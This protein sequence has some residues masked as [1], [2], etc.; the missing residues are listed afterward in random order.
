[1]G[2]VYRA[3]DTR[4]GRTVALKILPAHMTDSPE[5]MQRFER[6]ARAISRCSHPHVCA[7]YDVGH[8]D[9]VSFLVLEYLEGETLATRLERGPLPVDELLRIG[10]EVAGALHA[11]HRLGIVHRDLKP[12]NIMLTKSGAKLLD[13]G[14]AK[15]AGPKP[16]VP[17]ATASPTVSRPLTSE[18][19]I[20]GTVQYMAPEQLEGLDSGAR[21]DV[22]AL[23]LVLYEMATGQHPFKGRT[24]ASLIA[25]ILKEEPPPLTETVPLFPRALD[26]I[27]RTCLAKDPDERWQSAHDVQL[28]L[29]RLE[30]HPEPSRPMPSGVRRLR[31]RERLAWGAVLFLSTAVAFLGVRSLRDVPEAPQSVRASLLPPP[32]FSFQQ[33]QFAISPDGT[34][35]AFVGEDDAARRTLWVRSLSGSG[36]QQVDGAEDAAL[37]FWAPDGRRIG[38]FTRS[39]KLKTVDLTTGAVRELG[40]A[41]AGRGGTWNGE[42]VIVFSPAVDGPL[43]RVSA[44]G[45]APAPATRVPKQDGGQAHR[46]PFF[47]PDGKRFFFFVDWS[48]PE[49]TLANGIYVGSLEGGDAK[50][51]SSQIT[52]NVAYASGYLLFVQQARLVAQRFDL[53]RLTVEGPPI[54]LPEMELEKELAFSYAGFSVSPNGVL[55][56]RSA[57]D[58]RSHLTWFDAEG[59]ELGRLPAERLRDPQLSR[60]GQRL[61]V[62]SDD[63][64]D[65][66]R[67]IRSFDLARGV[68]TR[69]TETGTEHMPVWSPD[70]VEIAYE[71][72]ADGS[73][74]LAVV[75]VDGSTPPRVLLQGPRTIPVDWAPDGR[76]IIMNFENGGPELTLVSSDEGK[77]ETM[78][79]GAEAQLSPDGKWIAFFGPGRSYNEIFVQPFPGPGPRLQISNGGG[80][81]PRWSSDGRMIYY[82]APDRKLMAV[83]IDPSA[84]APRVLFETRIVSPNFV[85]LQYDVSP[86]GRF[87]INSFPSA[88]VSPLTLLT[89]WTRVLGR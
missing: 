56:F 78:G 22:F 15:R 35:L 53:D 80:A 33:D 24:P 37:P 32:G 48:R 11:A 89:N 64:G 46:F 30:P 28:Q 26:Q 55:V 3:R 72:F 59:N 57:V 77:R 29:K 18:G 21:T 88:S 71:S 81:Q 70:G 6:E 66:R 83:R 13:F 65:G 23:G 5:A 47:L 39:G 63:A 36:A 50:L 42:D 87:L 75:P 7:L 41:P 10:A 51:I 20:V 8:H 12:G 14:L 62:S 61:A 16:E 82:I 68:S 44:G 43:L 54:P 31:S 38:F 86:D 52:G 25:A 4:L 49:N 58:N 19:T 40:D 2:E 9:A 85:G 34:R 74:A 45:G 27:V 69:L 17:D 73:Y 84:S 76:L 67:F 79:P 60:D 1:M